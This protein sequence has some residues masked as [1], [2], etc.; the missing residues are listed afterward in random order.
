M[1]SDKKPTS[2]ED[3]IEEEKTEAGVGA[4]PG[5]SAGD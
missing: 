3:I 2:I 5:A 4:K 1:L